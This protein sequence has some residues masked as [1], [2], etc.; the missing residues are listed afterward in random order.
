MRP[1]SGI[2]ILQIPDNSQLSEILT[3]EEPGIKR[4][5]P[6]SLATAKELTGW[7]LEARGLTVSLLV[8]A[9]RGGWL[10]VELDDSGRQGWLRPER[11]WHFSSWEVFLKGKTIRFLRNSPKKHL[12]LHDKPEG[13]LIGNLSEKPLMK[14]IIASGDWAYV[15]IG[16]ADSGWIRWRETDGRLLTAVE[17][18]SPQSR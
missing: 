17:Q 1:Y 13:K 9:A 10:R 8:T 7:L 16:D 3:Y 4:M 12:Q 6:T 11:T 5:P 2:G 15:I 14:V 18:Q